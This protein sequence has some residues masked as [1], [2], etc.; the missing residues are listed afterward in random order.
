MTA[1]NFIG[2]IGATEN[3]QTVGRFN[4]SKGKDDKSLLK[5][6]KK[7]AVKPIGRT[8]GSFKSLRFMSSEKVK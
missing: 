2:T 1:Q 8:V 3:T 6:M 4:L 7:T 5:K